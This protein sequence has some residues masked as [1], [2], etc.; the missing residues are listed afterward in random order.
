MKRPAF[1]KTAAPIIISLFLLTPALLVSAPAY[2]TNSSPKLVVNV[3]AKVTG[4]A[5][6]G[7]C[8]YWAVDHYNKQIQIW[9][10][11]DGNFLVKESYKGFWQTTTGAVSPGADCTKDLPVEGMTAS[12][13]FSGTLSFVATGTFSPTEQTNGFIGSFD[14][15]TT[16]SDLLGTYSTQTV[17]PTYT[18]MLTFYFPSGFSYVPNTPSPFTFT[19]HYQG[20][21]WVD[22][23]SGLTGNIVT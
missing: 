6:S 2:A 14:F 12:G 13:T 23:S 4:D 11:S 10:L 15:G 9:Q 3:T 20:Q 17:N 18:D 19:Y 1:A 21:T 22:A 7:G 5:D 8:S 16:A